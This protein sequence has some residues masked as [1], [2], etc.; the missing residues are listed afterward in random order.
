[1]LV[2]HV[3]Y[4]SFE[5]CG[6]AVAGACVFCNLHSWI[7]AVC[8]VPGIS[9]AVAFHDFHF[10]ISAENGA[11]LLRTVVLRLV[12]ASYLSLGWTSQACIDM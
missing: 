7:A 2:L 11:R 3:G 4:L 12:V 9:S 8:V 1:M 10:H 6:D 5:A